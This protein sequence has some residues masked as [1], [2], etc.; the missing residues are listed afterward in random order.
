MAT[1]EIRVV[2][3]PTLGRDIPTVVGVIPASV[4]VL[5]HHVPH[6]DVI[7]NTGYQ[8]NPTASRISQLANDLK[9][10]NVDLPTS[11]ML[12]LRHVDPNVVLT[13]TDSDNYMLNLDADKANNEYRLYVVDGQ[14]RIGALR[15]AIEDSPGTGKVKIPFVCML[16]ADENYEMRQFH[17]VNSN[18]KS[19]PTDLAYNLLKALA[20]GNPD[21]QDFL[22]SKGKKWQIEAQ[23]IVEILFMGS[24]TWK[25]KIRMP[26]RPK[27][28]SIVP[29]ASFVRSLKPLLTQTALFRNIKTAKR[30]AQVIDAYWRAMRRVLPNPF[31]DSAKYSIQKGIGVDVMHSVF[32]IILD[33][34]RASGHSLFSPDAYEPYLESILRDIEGMNGSGETVQGEEFWRTGRHGAVGAFSS[35]AGKRRLS[36]YIQSKLPELDL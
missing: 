4:L 27:G 26:N 25:G 34:A 32:P 22:E 36:D 33:L 24:A 7:K 17:T 6:R 14:H 18:A 8:R 11:V 15:K 3:G 2:R 13:K 19:V 23:N 28:D 35:A 9:R 12:N 5:H 30:Q 29:S 10:E 1:V 31:E 20:E 21:Y 16:G